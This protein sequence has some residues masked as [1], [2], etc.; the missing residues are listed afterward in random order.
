M[1]EDTKIE[2]KELMVDGGISSNNFVMQFLA[3]LL[4]KDVI[5]M[6]TQDVSALGAAYLA[7][8]K[9]ILFE[10]INSKRSLNSEKKTYRP[11]KNEMTQAY[12]AGW[13]KAIN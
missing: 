7:G 9:K 11:G 5:N 4:Q 10:N 12:Y 3:D 8:L 6:G 1:E 13:V 2:L